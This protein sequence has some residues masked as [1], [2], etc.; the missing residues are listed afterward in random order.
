MI[1][2]SRLQIDGVRNLNAVDLKPGA[3]INL[4]LGDNG[5]GKTSLLEAL[6][7]LSRGRSFLGSG[8]HE[9]LN[10]EQRKAVIVAHLARNDEP[11]EVLGIQREPSVWSARAGGQDIK[12]LATLA[13]KLPFTVFHP[14]LHRL[15]EGQPEDRR[16]FLDFGVFHV[17]HG[18]LQH[19]RRYRTT[20]RQRNAAIRSG[21]SINEITVWD[22]ALVEHGE[23]VAQYRRSHLDRI[24]SFAAEHL[25]R[26]SPALAKISLSLATGWPEDQTLHE[27]LGECLGQDR[28]LGFTS[29]GPHRGDVRMVSAGQRIAG[30][31]SR[32]QQKMVALALLLAQSEAMS[33]Q[34]GVPVIGF[35]DLPSE[36]DT[37]HQRI[38]VEVVRRLGAQIWITGNAAPPGVDKSGVDKV[39]HVEQGQVSELV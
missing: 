23:A 13:E 9:F 15:I 30:R 10:R 19:W 22:Q 14:G 28:E 29:R 38:A 1:R 6:H 7:C 37:E 16:R 39:F 2:V 4:F 36:L 18:F 20:L 35:D 12:S 31:L 17:E 5:A 26:F 11:S 21:A 3:G 33:E 27:A 34:G 25:Q 8:R 32:G 24:S